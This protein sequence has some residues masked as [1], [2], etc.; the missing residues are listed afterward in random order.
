MSSDFLYYTVA[1]VVIAVCLV[2]PPTEFISAGLTVQNV[3]SGFLGSEQMNFI[4][5][6]VRRTC[7]TAFFHSVIPLAYYLF[8]FCV[9]ETITDWLPWNQRLPW[10]LFI[11]CSIT[12]PLI[13]SVL[14]FYWSRNKWKKH[15][16][17]QS[18]E[19]HAPQGSN[20][21]SVASSIDVEFRRIDKFT[22][23][24]H[25][26]RLIVTDSW[27]IQMST[28]TLY[29]AHQSDLHLQLVGAD[30]H[31][32]SPEHSSGVQFLNI[33]VNTVNT[34]V[35]P[36]SIRILASDYNELRTKLQSPIVNARNVMIHQS[37]SD[38]F[39]AAFTEQVE[40]NEVF[41]K[42]MDMELE[43]CIG[44]MQEQASVKLVK[45][46]DE[47]NEGECVPC[48]CRP[49]WCLSCM[50]KWFCS[51]QDQNQPQLWMSSRS[52]CP[53]CRSKFCMLDV[54]AIV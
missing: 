28:Y 52:P 7:A 50:G 37:L 9:A 12:L 17:A 2:L 25:G 6:H 22:S 11:L 40:R 41:H 26:K 16:I 33:I 3:L 43:P 39:L 36:F 30:E 14:I 47:Q 29:I 31:S 8:G 49:M 34:A 5:F 24:S 10:Q 23:G 53:T 46:C 54:C 35:K 15:P 38:R 4:H 51:R 42:P 20:W 19:R 45:L 18:L 48:Y 21:H 13:T 27:L 32:I 44:C 1:Y